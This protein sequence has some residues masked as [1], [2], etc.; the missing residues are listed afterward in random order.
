[1]PLLDI[2]AI[3]KLVGFATGAALHL[4]LAW[5]LGLRRQ[6]RVGERALFWLGLSL[7]AWHL[8]NFIATVAD[9]LGIGGGPW[10]LRL[11]DTI[12]YAALG[13][14]PPL[15]AHAHFRLW[16]L[17]DA[18]A[19]SRY[20]APFIWL[21]YVPLVALPWALKDLWLDPYLPPIERLSPLL[22]PFIG[23][24]VLIF[25]ECAGI[26]LLIAS[27]LRAAREQRF[28]R[29]F[30]LT[31]AAIGALFLVTYVFGA[32]RWD[33]IGRYLDAIARLSSLVP[34]AII[35]YYIYRYRYL[36]LVIRQSLVYAV[37]AVVVLMIYIYGIRRLSLAF[38]ERTQLSSEIV[39]A[40]LILGLMFLA[41]P[42]KRVT[43]R[44]LQRLFVREVGLYR[45]LVAQ[46]GAQAASYSELAHF[47]SFAE[48]RIAEALDL[49]RVQLIPSSVAQGVE[50]ELIR[51]AEERGW[52]EI[53]ER[54][55]LD[56]LAAR[57]SYALWR[58]GRVVGLLVI[59]TSQTELTVEKREVLS[60]LAGHLAVAIENGQL[61]GEKVKLERELAERERL[62]ALGQMAA[63]VA[64]EIKNPLS[65]IKSIAQV[66]REDEDVSREY[67]RDLDLITG[68]IDRLS[69][70]VSQLLSF[71]RPSVVAA[72]A[73]KLSVVIV[74]VTSLARAELDERGVELTT[75][76]AIDPNLD[77]ETVAGLKEIL[78]N[79]VLNAAQALIRDGRI[80]IESEAT[81]DGRLRLAVI[82]DGIGIP[83]ALQEKIFEPFFTTKQRGTGLGLAIVARR[84]REIGGS[85]RLTSPAANG[86]GARFELILPLR[87]D[88]PA[89]EDSEYIRQASRN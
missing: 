57:A 77:G 75:N 49:D 7:G 48:G 12:T 53:E 41:G 2:L 78:A 14:L 5:L 79:L 55:W 6:M 25:S 33:G 11:A 67:G 35:A 31:L 51:V 72:S 18:K 63:T 85:I 61:L 52:R 1:M 9:R 74:G 38:E 80:N 3:L 22:I 45:E 13:M 29:I 66:M 39:E 17:L 59:G 43:E 82:D 81:A 71:S 87:L 50:E 86:R 20:F 84:A 83:P 30:G 32:W 10:W 40:M 19:P 46:V 24:F 54:G 4:Y 68:E 64:H 47:V 44:Y 65:S 36:E 27:R 62:V 60:V 8:G 26:D 73:A 21:G 88:L 23:W 15:L 56:R 58:E 37:F 76:L 42:L 16:E 34:T 28:F 70:S 69:R 89:P